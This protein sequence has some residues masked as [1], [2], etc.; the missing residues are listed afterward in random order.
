MF[1]SIPDSHPYAFAM[2]AL[3]LLMSCSIAPSLMI[4]GVVVEKNKQLGMDDYYEAGTAARV[5]CPNK[6]EQQTEGGEEVIKALFDNIGTNHKG[7][8][9]ALKKFLFER[10]TD[11]TVPNLFKGSNKMNVGPNNEC[12]NVN[13]WLLIPKWNGKSGG[14]LAAPSYACD[15]CGYDLTDEAGGG[16]KIIDDIVGFTK[17]YGG[18]V[19]KE[20]IPKTWCHNPLPSGKNAGNTK[21]PDTVNKQWPSTGGYYNVLF[22]KTSE[23][24]VIGFAA[25][26]KK[27][28]YPFHI[29]KSYELYW[30]I[31][32]NASWDARLVK[33]GG[34][35][36][37]IKTYSKYKVNGAEYELHKHDPK[38]TH[39][40][41]TWDTH[42][43]QVYFWSMTEN[44]TL[45][46]NKYDVDTD[47]VKFKKKMEP[48][49]YDDDTYKNIGD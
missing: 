45:T 23:Y 18:T 4:D 35:G 8:E 5:I 25:E 12:E 28:C 2:A 1:S 36:N 20:E 46:F 49:C 29:H 42:T 26:K 13:N 41:K 3:R 21:R 9:K 15:D 39:E 7:V 30:P 47:I 37:G 33:T 34:K 44:D 40:I 27:T 22:C 43:T 11:D 38:V 19:T 17:A 31:G 14:K 48:S 10:G 32:G 6:K 16:L 24:S